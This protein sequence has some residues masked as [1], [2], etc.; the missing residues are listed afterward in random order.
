MKNKTIALRNLAILALITSFFIACDKD[1]ATIESDI[2]NTNNATNFDALS[3]QF[4]VLAYSKAL[5]PVQTSALPINLLG[6]YNDPIYG[7]TTG[8]IVTQLRP[9]FLDPDFGANVELDSVVLSIP[10]FSTAVDIQSDGETIYELDSVFGDIDNSPM[11]LSIYE[12]NYFLRDFDP[13]SSINDSQIYYSNQTTGTSPIGDTQL[14]GTLLYQDDVFK[15]RPR[16][17]QLKNTAGELTGYSVPALRVSYKTATELAYWNEKIIQKSG[18]PELSTINNFNDYFRGIY[19]KTEDTTNGEGTMSL[20]NLASSNANITLYIT[21]DNSFDATLDQ[22]KSSV[23]FN[24]T[25]N[26]VNFLSNDFVYPVGDENLGDDKLFL[27]GGEGSIA[28]VKLFDGEDT[29]EDIL[30][31]SFEYFK[32]EFVEIDENGKFIKSKKLINE[33]NL[34]FYVDQTSVAN[35]DEELERVLLYDMKNNVPLIDYFFAESNTT[36]PLDSRTNHLGRLERDEN[37]KGLRY[38]IRITE[39]I[40]N[41]LLNDSTNVDLGLVVS[42][43]V[44]L[45]SNI[46]PY[47]VLNSDDSID[48]VPISSIITQRG[49]VLFGNNT[50]EDEKKLYLEI[51]YTEPNN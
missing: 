50:M 29:D 30:F 4:D 31:N 9:A 46:A 22:V 37:G 26:R 33:A 40:N 38:K 45:E 43:N 24:F 32:N 28:V 51:F 25:G 16:Q 20:L 21:S 8:N 5:P 48:K 49:T 41:I 2:V 18:Q 13:N 47:D 39:H 15:P 14:E 44:N 12:S 19:F 27:K 34:V 7:K 1:F 11:K 23:V 6:V 42:G 3:R 36:S 35:I 17:I 10:Y